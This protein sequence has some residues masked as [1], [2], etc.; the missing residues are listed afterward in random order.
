M[1]SLISLALFF[2]T[3][4]LA[5][6]VEPRKVMGTID[7]ESSWSPDGKV[8]AFDSIR[9]GK[10]NI[11]TWKIDTRELKRI[12]MTDAN[13]FTPE[14]SPDGKQLAFVSDRT[15]HN[16][17]FSVDLA[18]GSQRQLTKDNSDDIHPHWSPDGE[19]VIYCPARDNPNQP[20][21]P[22][23]EIY[24]IYT[25]KLDGSDA[26]RITK[27]KGINTYPS[28]SPDGRQ[29]LFRKVLTAKDS[30]VFVMNADGTAM[31]NLTNNPAFDAWPRWSFDHAAQGECDIFTIDAP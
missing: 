15:G 10:L 9:S 20:S 18:S 26:K 24:E 6:A 7:E 19:C 11:Y 2:P 8:I 31:R 30:E 16:E 28:Y 21:A 23:G 27:D 22:E 5:Q 4:V 17:I 29:V 3:I 1:K 14:F 12:T 25:I 13:D